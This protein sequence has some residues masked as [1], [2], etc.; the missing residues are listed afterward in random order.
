MT[1]DK[2]FY[3]PLTITLWGQTEDSH[4]HLMNHIN[5]VFHV[6]DGFFLGAAAYALRDHYVMQPPDSVL[7]IHG[8]VRWFVGHTFDLHPTDPNETATTIPSDG[9]GADPTP[10]VK[11]KRVP[12]SNIPRASELLNAVRP[13]I[14]IMY[15][16]ISA[17][18]TAG[19]STLVYIGYL[20]PGLEARLR[21][22]K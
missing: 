10:Q 16:L 17:T 9:A 15:V 7:D 12:I 13:S 11:V 21:K 14:V 19:V 4:F 20:K 2:A 3:T 5:F 1:K 18:V 6:F 8:P 22:E